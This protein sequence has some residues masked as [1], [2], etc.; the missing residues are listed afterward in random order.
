MIIFPTS[1]IETTLKNASA[2]DIVINEIDVDPATDYL[3]IRAG[4]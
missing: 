4:M 1:S 2:I 3:Y